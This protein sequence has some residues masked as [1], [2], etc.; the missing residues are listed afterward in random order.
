MNTEFPKPSYLTTK[1]FQDNWMTVTFRGWRKNG[2]EDDPA[3]RQNPKTWKQKLKF[4]LPYSYP[5]WAVDEAGEKKLGR[6]GEPFRNKYW[7]KDYPH[8]YTIVY[9]FDEGELETGSKPL[10]ES[11]CA[12]QPKVGERLSI[13]RTGEAKETKWVVKRESS[14]VSDDPSIEMDDSEMEPDQDVP[15]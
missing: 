1:Q 12:V 10:F 6:D 8:G 14:R 3:D 9:V 7:D 13:L 5:E 2:N 11:F 15:F 4:M